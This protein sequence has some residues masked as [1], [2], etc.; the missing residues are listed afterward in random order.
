[1][2]S[3]RDL[4]VNN[5]DEAKVVIASVAYDLSASVGLGASTA[6]KKLRELSYHL[7]AATKD[8]KSIKDLKIYDLLD[9]A[10]N[11]SGLSGLYEKAADVFKL[12]K[13]PI[14]IGG[15]H[16]VSIPL[17][18]AFYYYAKSLGKTPAIIHI[19]AHPDFCDI[20]DG[21]K[22]SH[23]CTNFRAYEEG[24]KLEDI[25]LIGIRGYEE[26]EIELFSKH[27]EL[28]IIN[29]S[30]INEDNFNVLEL[31][32]NKLDDK[33]LI[34]LSF[35]IDAID[36]SFAPGTG[37]PETFGLTPTYVN[38]L[39]NNIISTLPVGAWDIVEISPALDINDITSW[40][41]LKIMYEV[42]YTLNNK[43]K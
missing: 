37:T 18:T 6:P 5:L 25:V 24:Y 12:G 17:Q 20:Y 16:S 30:M 36:P 33:Y 4:K 11:E 32:K 31:L 38:K 9:L 40:T 26:Q 1:M 8:G 10:D 15:D 19:D 41:T 14:F 2:D 39:I 21:S 13:F 43:L 28:S 34:Y 3:W 35:D 29:A 42:F 23:A 27:P 7:P 22:F